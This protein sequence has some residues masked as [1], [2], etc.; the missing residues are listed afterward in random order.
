MNIGVEK[1][2]CVKRILWK[3]HSRYKETEATENIKHLEI[4]EWLIK[5]EVK[6]GIT[7]NVVSGQFVSLF[8]TSL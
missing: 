2:R 3:E 6:G 5:A 7:L 4:K 8:L 1:G